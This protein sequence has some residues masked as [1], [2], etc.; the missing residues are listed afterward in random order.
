[1]NHLFFFLCHQ[2]ICSICC[3]H[4]VGDSIDVLLH[5]CLFLASFAVHT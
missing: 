5:T 2:Y 4:H 3:G 1:L